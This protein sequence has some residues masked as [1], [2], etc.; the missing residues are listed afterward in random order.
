MFCT[1]SNKIFFRFTFLPLF[2][3]FAWIFFSSFLAHFAQ[4]AFKRQNFRKVIWSAQSPKKDYSVVFLVV[5]FNTSPCML[6][7]GNRSM[8]NYELNY[9]TSHFKNV[10]DK[11]YLF[12][13]LSIPAGFWISTVAIFWQ[14]AAYVLNRRRQQ[15]WFSY[16]L[17]NVL[18][19][20]YAIL[21]V[22]VFSWWLD[23]KLELFMLRKMNKVWIFGRFLKFCWL[24]LF[25]ASCYKLYSNLNRNLFF[26]YLDEIAEG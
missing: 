6:S 9:K 11:K 1:L 18:W 25:G 26:W 13:C 23:I 15:S 3:R 17:D 4:C 12:S 5:G 19:F 7:L 22:F 24:L 20:D 14:S 10:F 2:R 8:P 16:D 21:V